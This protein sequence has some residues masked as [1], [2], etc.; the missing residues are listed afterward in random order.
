MVEIL[1]LDAE[2]CGG[3]HCKSTGFVG[4]IRIRKTKRI[5]DGIVRI[6]YSSGMAAIEDMQRDKGTVE[7][8]TEQLNSSADKLIE[9]AE[10]LQAD[11]RETLKKVEL[12]AHKHDQDVAHNLLEN[13]ESIGDIR[14]VVH[15]TEEDENGETI[16]KALTEKPKVLAVI[17]IAEK[18]AK[19]L[20][21]RSKDVD[22]DCRVLLKE[23]MNLLGG[24]GGG[25]PEYAQGGGGDVE[26][27]PETLKRVPGIVRTVMGKK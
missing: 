10:K 6:E 9:T 25:K 27:L 8:L 13:A 21:S 19:V 12:L 7:S 22:V 20:V 5:Q 17:G 4:A 2:A 26:K 23:I 16:S 11:L 15:Q 1:G 18:K 14:L 3:L 24:G